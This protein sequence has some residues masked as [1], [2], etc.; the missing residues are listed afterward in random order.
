M[1][2]L[3]KVRL[4]RAMSTNLVTSSQLGWEAGP[5]WRLVSLCRVTVRLQLIISTRL[6][7]VSIMPIQYKG[8]L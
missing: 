2:V 4:V 7:N 3:P 5:R 1:C 6:Y 8:E